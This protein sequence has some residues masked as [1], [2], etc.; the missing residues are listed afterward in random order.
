M[1]SPTNPYEDLEELPALP[2]VINSESNDLRVGEFMVR[3][4]RRLLT[5]AV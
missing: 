5:P 2:L 4:D 3:R 1:K